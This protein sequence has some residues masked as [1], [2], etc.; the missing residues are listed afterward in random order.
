MWKKKTTDYGD[1]LRASYVGYVT[2]A[3]VNNLAP[4][5]FLIFQETYG[6][7]V[8]QITVMIT[9]NFGIQLLIDLMSAAAVERVGYR[10]SV[11]FAH[12]V[13]A[14]GIGAMAVLPG[15]GG[16]MA[17]AV[18]YAVG[19]GLI[20]VLLSPIV[21]ACP[22]KEKS[23][24]MSL[25]HSFYCWGHVL[26][27]LGSTLFFG[28]VGREHWRLLCLLWALVPACNAV[29]FARVPVRSL[30]EEG[31][32]APWRSWITGR[33][34]VISALL[35]MGAGGA[36]QAMSQWAS[37]FAESGLGVS[38]TVGDLAG[39][40]LFAA[41][42]GCSRVLYAR[43]GGKVSVKKSML[44]GSS[45]CLAGYAAA[46]Y[47]SR[48]IWSLAGCALCG[49][50]VGIMWPSTFSLAAARLKGG[51]TAMFALLSM[52]GDLGCMMGP[53]TVGLAA[54]ASRGIRSGFGMA[55]IFPAVMVLGVLLLDRTESG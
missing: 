24:S 22:T 36:E 13:S 53:G 54:E 50:A 6:V 2:Q 5:L 28:T 10:R 34:F 12:V 47:A 32:S 18:L 35:M 45:L 21:E 31:G 38:K 37:V 4:L 30:K 16:L 17:A 27:V 51:G 29:R 40:C 11:V 15:F 55:V 8:R 1:T 3:I 46:A 26:V 20:E 33:V 41:L 42:M 9:M 25:L 49:L 7:T 44:L 52:A 14:A 19:G 48:P 43:M 39:P 23:A